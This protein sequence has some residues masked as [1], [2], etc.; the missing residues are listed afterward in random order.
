MKP[1][2]FYISARS[3]FAVL[4]PGLLLVVALAWLA[5]NEPFSPFESTTG[6]RLFAYVLAGY[7]AGYILNALVKRFIHR[8]PRNPKFA[9]RIRA[10]PEPRPEQGHEINPE[11]LEIEVL[12]V[13]RRVDPVSIRFVDLGHWC[14][15][16]VQEKSPNLSN[17]FSEVETEVEF[18]ASMPPALLVLAVAALVR[19]WPLSGLFTALVFIG[20]AAFFAYRFLEMRAYEQRAWYTKVLML[21]ALG[22]L[23]TG[24]KGYSSRVSPGTVAALFQPNTRVWFNWERYLSEGWSTRLVVL[25]REEMVSTINGPNMLYAPWYIGNRN[26]IVSYEELRAGREA[27]PIL[28]RG[29]GDHL[30]YFGEERRRRIKQ[31]SVSL[32]AEAPPQTVIALGYSLG[33]DGTIILDGNHRMAALFMSEADFRVAMFT[34]NGPLQVT[35]AADTLFWVRSKHAAGIGD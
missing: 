29:I 17:S 19:W 23:D 8:L 4:I 21:D 28:I 34:I 32:A 13:A 5:S 22:V 14:R 25:T 24:N 33:D 11:R 7:I 2:D 35:A 30:A 27:R 10:I 12:E 18:L 26:E 1:A 9:K 3:F 20:V 16:I 31:L 15:R 6:A